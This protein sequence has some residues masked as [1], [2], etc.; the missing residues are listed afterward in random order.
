[1]ISQVSSSQRSPAFR[2]QPLKV[3]KESGSHGA[4]LHLCHGCW[5]LFLALGCGAV[6]PQCCQW[7]VGGQGSPTGH[8]L[9]DEGREHPW[10]TV[11]RDWLSPKSISLG[12]LP[13]S[14]RAAKDPAAVVWGSR[15]QVLSA[16]CTEL[17]PVQEKQ[18]ADRLLSRRQELSQ[19]HCCDSE[20]TRAAVWGTLLHNSQ[21]GRWRETCR[22]RK[23]DGSPLHEF[24]LSPAP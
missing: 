2:F 22:E 5:R 1:M 6:A 20:G 19:G 12:V 4:L 15:V 17:L 14:A 9:Q 3:S 11:T 10:Q 24:L 13:L 16:G 21:Q 7:W 23:A 8:D 18:T